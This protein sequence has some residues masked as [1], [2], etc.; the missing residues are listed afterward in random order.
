MYPTST[1]GGSPE[2]EGEIYCLF[3]VDN[4]YIITQPPNQSIV[5]ENRE[6]QQVNTAQTN[7]SPSNAILQHL[8]S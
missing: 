4:R 2:G 3:G 6:I 7:N 8:Y 5:T 1:A